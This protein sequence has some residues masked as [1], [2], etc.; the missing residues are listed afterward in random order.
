MSRAEAFED[1][2][3]CLLG[4]YHSKKDK[5]ITGLNEKLGNYAK[6]MYSMYQDLA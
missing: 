2:F 1:K 4:T 3:I 6:E 5:V